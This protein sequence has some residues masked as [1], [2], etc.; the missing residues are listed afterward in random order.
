M[1]RLAESA[2]AALATAVG[3]WA[4]W[5]VA[6]PLQQLQEQAVREALSGDW[7]A[8]VGVTTV[9]FGLGGDGDFTLGEVTGS[10]TVEGGAILLYT[11]AAETVEYDF[12]LQG[13][14]LVLSGGDLRAPVHFARPAP[15]PPPPA[16]APSA[17]EPSPGIVAAEQARALRGNLPGRWSCDA[18]KGRLDLRLGE[19]GRFRFGDASGVY[20]LTGNA[21]ALETDASA[22]KYQVDLSPQ[23]VMTLSGGDLTQPLKF[24]RGVQAGS[25]LKR[26]LHVSPGAVKHKATRLCI[27][28]VIVVLARLAV[29]LLKRLSRFVVYSEWGMLSYLYRHHKSRVLTAHSLA[30]NLCK[31]VVYFS[32]LGAVLTEMGVNYTAYLASLSVIGL[33][34]G[35]GSQGLVQDV[36]T[37]FFI[38]FEDQF[39]VD[40]LV[41]ISGQTGV[42]EEL[43]LRM[44]RLRNYFGQEVVIPNRNIAM[45]A[46]YSGTG[47]QAFVDIAVAGAEAAQ[48]AVPL[49]ETFGRELARQFPGVILAGPRVVHSLALATGEQFIRVAVSL[50]PQ[51]QWIV[52]QQLIPR[53]RELFKREG[54]EIPGDRAVAFYHVRD[55]VPTHAPP[56]SAPAP[57]AAGS[58]D[59]SALS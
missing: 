33:A 34:V 58:G 1:T 49:L 21:L 37:G 18:G 55:P 3:L 19:D 4:S 17:P 10:Y 11:D 5:A 46:N 2:V 25:A 29:Y 44:T 12:E 51:Q 41:E 42:V 15:P 56:T 40:D 50:W 45:V 27:I 57:G 30:L 59:K 23:D 43:G 14:V 28:V 8:S 52:D 48:K 7:V 53:V 9:E 6:G 22:L 35:F 20:K 32:A 24:A 39:E 31:Y 13:E 26:S 54:L 38:I 16:V 47:L 36:V